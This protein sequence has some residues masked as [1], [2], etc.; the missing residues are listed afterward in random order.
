M[1][2]GGSGIIS[3]ERAEEI[4]GSLSIPPFVFWEGG[5]DDDVMFFCWTLLLPL[6]CFIVFT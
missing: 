1:A 6:G 5:D 3:F 4:M 2:R